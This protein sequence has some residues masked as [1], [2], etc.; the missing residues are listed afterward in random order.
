[1][2]SRCNLDVH[3]HACMPSCDTF[4]WQGLNPHTLCFNT[5]ARPHLGP[6]LRMTDSPISATYMS[7]SAAM[8]LMLLSDTMLLRRRIC[9]TRQI[10]QPVGNPLSATKSLQA[11]AVKSRLH[12]PPGMVG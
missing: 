8:I 10:V 6:S 12:L 7:G 4:T 11:R 9:S 2:Y 1:M 5:H 3:T